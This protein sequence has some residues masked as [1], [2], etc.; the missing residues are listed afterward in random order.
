[1]T[2]WTMHS[3]QAEVWNN[4]ARFK[5]ITAGRRGGKSELGTM[6]IGAKGRDLA[7]RGK[8]G[9]IWVVLPTSG[10]L[11]T[12][13]RKFKRIIPDNWITDKSGTEKAPDWMKM[14][15]VIIQFRSADRPERL[16]AEGLR[17][18]WL[19]ESGIM[20]RDN[21]IWAEYI[22]PT[23]I[24]YKAPALI[25]GTPKGQNKFFELFSRGQDDEEEKYASF[26]WTSFANPYVPADE[27]EDIANDM[28]E[29]I[30]NQEILAEFLDDTASVFRG[31]DDA[32][33]G[34]GDKDTVAVGVDLAK[35]EDFTVLIG[36][37]EDSQIT[38]FDRFQ[39]ISWPLQKKRIVS[40]ASERGLSLPIPVRLN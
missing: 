27:I 17:A 33:T 32:V 10:E 20:L 3:R 13:W 28:P 9:V 21:D 5:T 34:Y 40:K 22:R 2:N 11:P 39:K 25:S 7:L 38:F 12:I 4:D 1:M 31:V 26:H 35:S 16:V 6:W 24:D 8:E 29:R 15:D 37:D 36:L 19:D 23:L 18:I 30:Y 14:G